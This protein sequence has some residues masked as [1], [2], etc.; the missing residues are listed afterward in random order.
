MKKTKHYILYVK[1]HASKQHK[2]RLK[3]YR[4]RYENG[5]SPR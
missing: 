5:L 2:A 1:Q 4:R 3:H